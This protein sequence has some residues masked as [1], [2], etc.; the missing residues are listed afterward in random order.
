MAEQL[1]SLDDAAQ[2]FEVGKSTLHRWVREGLLQRYRKRGDF[3]TF[4]DRQEL[5][6]LV[7]PRPGGRDDR[8]SHDEAEPGR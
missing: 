3:H 1:I 4:V 5:A 8:P 2:E 7:E 6:K